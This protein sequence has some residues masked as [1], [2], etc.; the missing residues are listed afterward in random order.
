MKLWS[1]LCGFICSSRMIAVML[2]LNQLI[3][4]LPSTKKL[5]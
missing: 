5:K 1:D 2:I 4:K 3:V